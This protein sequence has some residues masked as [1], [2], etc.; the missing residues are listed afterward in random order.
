[1]TGRVS[2]S[3]EEPDARSH[4]G[5]ILDELPVLPRRKN[6]TDA[7]AG[8]PAAFRQFLD[9]IGLRPPLVFRAVDDQFGIG[10]DDA[11]RARRVM[12]AFFCLSPG[13]LRRLGE[14]VVQKLF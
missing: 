11:G 14:A 13:N 1:M 6:V 4:F 12:R 8:R 5:I 7:L 2:D 10:E 9:P 3:R